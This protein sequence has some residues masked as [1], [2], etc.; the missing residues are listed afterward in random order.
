MFRTGPLATRCTGKA[1]NALQ[2][3]QVSLVGA[4]GQ[5]KFIWTVYTH[6]SRP[7]PVV[8]LNGLRTLSDSSNQQQSSKA[9][10]EAGAKESTEIVLTPG[11]KVVAG[12][13]LG[14]WAGVAVFASF[15][16]YYIG[17]ELFPTKMSPNSVMDAATEKIRAHPEVT[18]KFGSPIKVYG[19]DHGGHR[20]GRRNFIEHTEYTSEDDGTKRT[21]VRFNLEGPYGNA[22]VFAEVSKDMPSGELVYVLVQDKSN[23][24][25]INVVDNRSRL[26]AQ[27]LAGGN[28][29]GQKALSDLLGKRN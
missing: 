1:L 8:R 26:M 19:R 11:E 9:Q 13:R 3:H 12:T 18:R 28:K 7:A 15:C 24:R 14:V 23:G 4:S 21:R 2:K 6:S 20:E 17:K 5:K 29:E 16:A 22:F 25:V 27:R 10:S